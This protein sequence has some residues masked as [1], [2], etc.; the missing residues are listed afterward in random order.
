MDI[1]GSISFDV[2]ISGLR[3]RQEFQVL[4]AKT[5]K[6]ILLGRDFLSHFITIQFNFADQRIKLNGN[7]IPCVPPTDD[8]TVRVQR[9]INLPPRSENVVVVH[10]TKSQPLLTADFEPKPIH[11]LSGVYATDCRIT[12]DIHGNFCISVL[13]VTNSPVLLHSRQCIGTLTSLNG[14]IHQVT[15]HSEPQWEGFATNITMGPCLSAN[16]QNRL[17]HLVADYSRI[18]AANPRKPTVVTTMEHRIITDDSQPIRRKPYRIP[19]AWNSEV[20]DQIQQMLNNDIIR[21]SSSPWN[22]PV[23]LVKKKDNSMRF[24]CDFRGLNSVTKKD[25]YPLPHVRDVLD[26]MNGAKFWT[27]LDAASAYWS[28]PLSEKDKEKTAFSVPRG[29]FEF[30]VTPYGLCNA[31]ASYQRMMD[32]ALAGLPSDRILAYM[33]DIV[34]FSTTFD[35]HLKNLEQVFQRLSHSGISLKLSKCIFASEKVDFLGFELSQNGLTPQYR[36]TE[37]IDNFKRPETK[38]E[39]KSFLGLAGFYRSFIPNF[40]EIS[41]PLNR[42]TSDTVAFSW[43]D[44]CEQ[45]FCTLKAHLSSKPVLH[46]PHFGKPFIVEVDASNYACGG[47]LSQE[48]PS[49]EIH[50]IAYFSTSLQPAQQKWSATVKEAFALLCAVRHWHVYLAGTQFILKSDHNPLTYLRTQNDPRGKLSRWLSELE[51]YDYIIK[52]IPGKLNI[53][54]DALSRNKAANPVQPPSEFEDKI[55]ASF[56]NDNSFRVQ[57]L[58]E[59]LKDPII[60][61]TIDCI[62]RSWPLLNGKYK[63]V[64]LQLRLIDGLLTKSGRPVIPP[65]LRKIVV[66][67]IHNVAHF[68]TDKVYQLLKDRYYWPNMYN[69]IKAFSK[70][71]ETCQKTKCDSS[72]PKAPLVP[73]YIPQAPTQFVAID[74]AFLPKDQQGYQYM[75]LIGDV[76]SKFISA[77]P[78][79]EQT[80]TSIVDAFLKDWLYIH[81]TPMY[82]LS[83][84]GS[85]VDGETMKTLCNK[86]GIEKRRSSAYHSQGNGFA[87]RSIRTIKDLLR[88]V[89]L[90]RQLSQS[91]W[92]S[93][94]PEL[95]FALN[96]SVSSSTQCVPY[97]V[98]F[99]RS[100][101]LPHDITFNVVVS[102]R[103][104]DVL[105]KEHESATHSLL[106]DIFARI[107]TNLQ[108]SKT[109][110][111]QQYNTNIR[112]NNYVNGQKVWLKVK[113]Y[114][115]GENRKL[116][117]R[118]NGPW[119]VVRKLP[120][121][122]NF[123]IANSK[124][125]V[126]IVHH[127]RL[128]P[129]VDNGFK[130]EIP[131]DPI[132]GSDIVSAESDN[133]FSSDSDSEY[134]VSTTDE[135][136]RDDDQNHEETPEREQPRRERR[137][138]Y[139]PDTIPW[140]SLRI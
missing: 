139:L 9:A 21:P 127:D 112:F 136:V 137:F 73:M 11:G 83:D 56:A 43:D 2:F 107:M 101:V 60:S 28:M 50:P 122:V 68:G 102:D 85:N 95:V 76:F 18:F 26:Q 55:Y 22:S 51:E 125:E 128:S 54:A 97:N 41:H 14:T 78:L 86:F 52:Y 92:R 66:T 35:E 40:A 89:L 118:R 34:I 6:Y 62:Q 17:R 116:A 77:I 120:N 19:Y 79:K 42:L 80:A 117:P 106:Q 46:F 69:Y 27:T 16:E 82:L 4:N 48:N 65:S 113:H 129:V 20:N 94:L 67:E 36:L 49:G 88:S 115:T 38:K 29:K 140:G 138:R 7:W 105:P 31:G 114:K 57:L 123:E 133:L 61:N 108:I 109:Q 91:Q 44:T 37:A 25:S 63:R 84:Q 103:D 13:N 24:V 96:A 71:C 98:V 1:A 64:Q 72:P 53:K 111:Q 39:L 12:P 23:I 130:K 100:A 121:G 135:S 134:S 104:Q 90:H 110:M 93:L 30:N 99:G 47:I 58:E 45:A 15:S 70:G 131:T 5:Y 32:I 81:G 10:C 132:D 3:F 75:L 119:V 126:K 87:E 8:V 33:D 124:K 59:Q 74:F